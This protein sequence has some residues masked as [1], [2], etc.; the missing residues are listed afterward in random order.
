M[1]A[2]S[3]SSTFGI[4]PFAARDWAAAIAALELWSADCRI[5]MLELRVVERFVSASSSDE[6]LCWADVKAE[7]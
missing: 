2:V 1:G 5:E 3:I 6:R 4:S 7:C